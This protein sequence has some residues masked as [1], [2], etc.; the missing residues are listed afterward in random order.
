MHPKYWN[1]KALHHVYRNADS[2]DGNQNAGA[3]DAFSAAGAFESLLGD[4]PTDAGAPAPAPAAK[5][6]P[7]AAAA[8][9]TEDQVAERL[10]RE[11]AEGDGK[12]ADD[13]GAAPQ[14]FTIKVDGKDVVLTADE[15]AEHYKNGLRQQDYT[16]KTTEAAEQ[17]KVAEAQQVEA[18]T[19]RDEYAGKLDAFASQA[20]YELNAMRAQLTDELLQSDPLTYMQ[21]QRTAETRHAQ[22]QQAQQELQQING[23][24]QQEKT[25]EQQSRMQ[26][27]HQAL[28][29]KLPEWKDSAVADAEVVKIKQYL[30]SQG[31]KPEEM[32]FTDHRSILMARKAMQHDAL[33]ERARGAVKKVA[34]APLK[35]E[36]PGN[37]ESAPKPG[38]GRTTAMKKLQK[39]GSITDAAAAFE[40][41]T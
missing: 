7:A 37:A 12:S 14:S 29:D 4:E 21:I 26:A 9:E 35:V 34:S 41:F 10:A 16:K 40:Q 27:E 28:L 20:N 8:D 32:T 22:L 33:M 39:S 1:R 13:A 18:R 38:D 31:F 2:G 5:P 30:A 15:M 23:Q 19:K 6:E 36:S 3:L 11:Q 24:R 17:R 25:A